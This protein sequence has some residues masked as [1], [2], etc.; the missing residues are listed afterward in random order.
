MRRGPLSFEPIGRPRFK[1]RGKICVT[2]EYNDD[3]YTEE[4]IIAA[5]G[6]CAVICPGMPADV[7][8]PYA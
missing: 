3:E 6:P 7:E 8:S 1:G 4:L 5:I 2:V